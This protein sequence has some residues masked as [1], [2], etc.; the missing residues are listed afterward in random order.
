[1]MQTIP[2]RWQGSI[3]IRIFEGWALWTRSLLLSS[4]SY[5]LQK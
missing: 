4:R 3:S 1:L 5:N 2:G